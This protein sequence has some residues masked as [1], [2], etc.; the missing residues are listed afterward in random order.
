MNLIIFK[1]LSL[2]IGT[3]V[4]LFTSSMSILT[5]VSR[6]TFRA[7]HRSLTQYHLLIM[8]RRDDHPPIF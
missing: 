8:Q 2:A 3:N 1:E 7:L 6:S 5:D 4:I